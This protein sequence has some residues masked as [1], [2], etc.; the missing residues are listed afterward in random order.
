MLLTTF[1]RNVT[2]GKMTRTKHALWDTG[3]A[4]SCVS[5]EI[6]DYLELEKIGEDVIESA[7]GCMKVDVCKCLIAISKEEVFVRKVLVLPV[8]GTPAIIGM[9]IIRLG[10]TNIFPEGDNLRFTFEV[11]E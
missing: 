9:D 1:L 8:N 5:K 7:T 4:S 10:H 11:K 3:A 2:T 6:A